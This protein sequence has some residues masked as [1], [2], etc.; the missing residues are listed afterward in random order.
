MS[1][2]FHPRVLVVDDELGDATAFGRAAS[3]LVD[4]LGAC[5]CDVIEAR[6]SS[7]GRAIIDS[8]VVLDAAVVDWRLADED[9]STSAGTRHLLEDVRAVSLSDRRLRY[10]DCG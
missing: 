8:G 10:W 3:A 2:H 4:A 7:R 1:P 5:G 6:S 9:P